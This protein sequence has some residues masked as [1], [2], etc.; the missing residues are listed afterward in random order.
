MHTVVPLQSLQRYDGEDQEGVGRGPG[1]A[2]GLLG[3]R[4]VL[5]ALSAA[6]LALGLLWPRLL[7]GQALMTPVSQQNARAN[8]QARVAWFQNATRSAT[9]YGGGGAGGYGL[10][11]RSFEIWQ[12]T[13][14]TFK[15]TL[16]PTQAAAGANRLASLD[17]GLG[18]IEEAFTNY[19]QGVA[20][21]QSRT[22]AFDR[23]CQVLY[24]ASG[25]WLQQFNAD[26]SRLQVGWR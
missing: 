22:M 17:S 16:T 14:N 15:A 10:V 9:G 23:L 25:V 24:R 6:L 3:G 1:G 11:W 7:L 20:N 2:G 18:I 13:Y 19:Q 8:V 5:P 12:T 26:C 21:G 4:S